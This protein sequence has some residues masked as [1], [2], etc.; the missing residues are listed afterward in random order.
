MVVPDPEAAPV[1]PPVIVPIVQLKVLG[2]EAVNAMFV[3]APLQISIALKF[4]KTGKVLTVKV[5]ELLGEP[6]T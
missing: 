1:M 3:D 4:V 2:I 5:A 6:L